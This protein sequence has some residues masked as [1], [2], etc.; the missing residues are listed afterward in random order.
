MKFT[1]PFRCVVALIGVFY[2]SYIMKS[3]KSCLIKKTL[4]EFY[5]QPKGKYG[6]TGSCKN[7]FK[8]KGSE[9]RSENKNKI[10]KKNKKYRDNN[11]ESIDKYHDE[12][13]A[14]NSSKMNDYQKRYYLENIDKM[15]SRNKSYPKFKSKAQK[16][17]NKAI[18]KKE[19][20]RSELCELCGSSGMIDGHHWDYSKPLDVVWC[21]RS[22]HGKIHN[23]T[24]AFIEL[25]EI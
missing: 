3:C 13:R 11:K 9:Y 5:S 24:S 7:C 19:I 21:C 23:N 18:L 12:Y 20:S 14:K 25:M 22:C 4:T 8:L 1:T 6:V 17:L 16:L 10:S 2:W 15:K